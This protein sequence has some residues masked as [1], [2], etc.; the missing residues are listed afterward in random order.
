LILKKRTKEILKELSDAVVAYDKDKTVEVTKTALDEGVDPCT[1]IKDGLA[2][3]MAEAGKLYDRQEYFLADFVACTDMAHAVLDIL[4]P[5][6]KGK[7]GEMKGRVVIGTI[8]GDIHDIGKNLVAMTLEASGWIVHDLGT[9]VKAERFAEEQRKVN[10]GVVALS[11]MTTATI[12]AMPRV[13]EV[14]RAQ[15]PNV[16]IIVGGAAVT[17]YIAKRYGA[18]GYADTAA[19]VVQEMTDMLNRL[20]RR[21]S[22]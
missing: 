11:G 20:K 13:I 19:T 4:R 9:D 15:N 3:A 14:V 6:L 22:K 17:R 10:A 16:A 21:W 5:H 12:T 8:E 7:E 1:V 18:D 2:T